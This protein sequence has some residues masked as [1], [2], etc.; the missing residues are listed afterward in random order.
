[1]LL[2]FTDANTQRSVAVNPAFVAVVYET[3]LNEESETLITVI[4]TTTGNIPVDLPMIEVVGKLN[5]E[6]K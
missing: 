5:G 2:Y 6:L 1:M 3:K 4:N